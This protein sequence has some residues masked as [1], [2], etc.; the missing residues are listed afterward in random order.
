MKIELTRLEAEM[1]YAYLVHADYTLEHCT[2]NKEKKMFPSPSHTER[3]IAKRIENLLEENL[4]Y[5]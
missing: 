3:N 5:R 2:I 4:G 1:F